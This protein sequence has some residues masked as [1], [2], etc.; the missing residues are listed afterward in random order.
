MPELR[1]RV[2]L[3]VQRVVGAVLAPLWFPA[4]V[5]VMRFAMRWRIEEARALR[6]NGSPSGRATELPAAR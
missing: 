2:A 1:D 3:A 4:I 5:G 6:R